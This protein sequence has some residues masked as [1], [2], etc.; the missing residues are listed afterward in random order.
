[1]APSL[2]TGAHVA[3]LAVVVA[4]PQ[5]SGIRDAFE[6]EVSAIYA[7]GALAEPEAK[8]VLN[9]SSGLYVFGY[10][11]LLNQFS[12]IR[13]MC[14]LTD[15]TEG[16][17]AFVDNNVQLTPEARECIDEGKKMDLILVKAKGVKRGWY[18]PGKLNYESLDVNNSSFPSTR[19]R[20]DRQALDVSPTYLGAV[21]DADACTY[22][23]IYPVSA[24]ELAALDKREA[25][26]FYSPSWLDMKGMEVVSQN[27]VLPPNAKVRW[28][29]MDKSVAKQ[30]TAVHPIVQSYV[31]IFVSGALQLQH[32]NSIDSFAVNVVASTAEWSEHW[33]NDRAFPYRTF[34][35]NVGASAVTRTLEEATMVDGSHL[36][37]SHLEAI[38]FP[39]AQ[40]RSSWWA[41]FSL[42]SSG[43][44]SSSGLTAILASLAPLLCA[45][46]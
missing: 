35:K 30:P 17:L 19:S 11:S 45:W 43:A 6:A 26:A 32:Q 28:Y 24:E 1:M 12:R 37:V 16:E 31:D 33:V 15:M 13:T 22:A 44:R 42:F 34:A 20:M 18:S 14:N 27:V 29:P 3:L 21:E 2:S 36:K 39:G 8:R 38:H 23:V 4:L 46:L 25:G 10:G 5:V 40:K 9:S 7:D 41:I